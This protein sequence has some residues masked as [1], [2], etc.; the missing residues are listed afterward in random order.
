MCYLD[1][2]SMHPRLKLFLQ[3][4]VDQTMTSNGLH[5]GSYVWLEN[6]NKY[7]G[8]ILQ[9]LVELRADNDHLEVRLTSLG[10]IVHVGLIDNLVDRE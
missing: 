7:E 9:D 8:N 4:R 6:V 5:L 1:G 2:K 3:A 10:H